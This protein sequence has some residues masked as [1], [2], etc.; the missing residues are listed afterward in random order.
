MDPEQIKQILEQMDAAR[1]VMTKTMKNLSEDQDYFKIA[2]KCYRSLYV[3][4]VDE[5]FT[6]EEALTI[7]KN[8]NP[9][10]R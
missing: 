7:L 10:M 6:N 2:A 5:G 3:A 9:M 4:L 8:Y 1:D